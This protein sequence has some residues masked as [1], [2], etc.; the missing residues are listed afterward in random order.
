MN[1]LKVEADEAVA[2]QEELKA[3]VKKLTEDNTHKE[4]ELTS[5]NNKIT[6]QAWA[7]C[8]Q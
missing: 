6:I 7:L 5:A 2:K 8:S 1:Q 3:E 4:T